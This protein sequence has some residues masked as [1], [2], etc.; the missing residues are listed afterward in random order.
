[1]IEELPSNVATSGP[2]DF[3]IV[4]GKRAAVLV[5]DGQIRSAVSVAESTS[6]SVGSERS[7]L[8]LANLALGPPPEGSGCE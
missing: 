4:V 3:S 7:M 6:L 8:T 2:I 1:M 5:I